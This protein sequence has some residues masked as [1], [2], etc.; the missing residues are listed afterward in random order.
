[1]EPT[2]VLFVH[3]FGS[4]STKCWGGF[5]AVLEHDADLAARG[6]RLL[7]DF[8]YTTKW[9]EL[10]PTRR[11]PDIEECGK[12]LRTFVESYAPEGRLMLVGHSMG[13]LVIQSYLA[14]KIGKHEGRD[15]ERVRLV[16][17]FATPNRGSASFSAARK[18]VERIWPNVQDEELEPLNDEV[19]KTS[20]VIVSSILGAQSVGADSC[21]IPF[22]VYWGMSDKIVPEV[23]ARGPF[24]EA[25]PL[26]GGHSEIVQP[27][28]KNPKD[29]RL[30]ALR[31]AL[32]D[33]VGHPWIYELDS[34][35]VN[36]AVMPN[37]P[38][39]DMV[40]QDVKPPKSVRTDNL[41][42]RQM[43]FLFS[44]Q[45]RCCQPWLQDYRS[46]DGWVQM[47][48][49]TGDNQARKADLT[50]YHE[51]GRQFTYVFAPEKSDHTQ[52]IEMNLQIYNGF[53]QGRRDWHDHV[54][55]MARFKQ[56]QVTLDLKKY[57]NAGWVLSAPPKFYYLAKDVEDEDICRQL[58]CAGQPVPPE[59]GDDP[60]VKTWKLTN[61]RSG[62]VHL[63]WDVKMP[64]E[65][66]TPAG[67]KAA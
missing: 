24:V 35:D 49:V 55:P 4:S 47:L 45:N 36:L 22:Q 21:P 51:T 37:D 63:A 5:K 18:V 48:N 27:D 46:K 10:N 42:I 9:F 32:L 52:T 29:D 6:Y 30:V 60:W 8:D 58:V 12:Y 20:D 11:I 41:A 57:A 67:P 65:G 38:E 66:T 31:S 23:S 59:A 61:V 28:P 17:T 16:V 43:R 64:A 56:Y 1:M 62:V 53:G 50:T 19:A 26:T 54:N 14:G 3:G 34:W 15:L 40:L 25:A 44:R 7:W 2:S 33:P 13:G 39:T